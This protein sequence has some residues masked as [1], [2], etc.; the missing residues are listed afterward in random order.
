MKS[1]F[2]S[3]SEYQEYLSDSGLT[4]ESYVSD[5]VVPTLK[6]TALA[7]K[8]LPE[9]KREDEEA[10]AEWIRSYRSELEESVNPMP[11]GLSYD[12]S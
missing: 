11:D 7:K 9:N 5:I 1:G 3:E 10:L 6:R 4:E 8:V 2:G 12:V